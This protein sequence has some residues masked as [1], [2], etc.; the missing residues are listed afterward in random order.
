MSLLASGTR[1]I[2]SV[3]FPSVSRSTTLTC[4]LISTI[5]ATYVI[6]LDESKGTAAK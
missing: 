1:A 5:A 2:V 3:Y 6:A 4:R